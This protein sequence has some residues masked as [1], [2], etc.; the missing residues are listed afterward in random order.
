MRT[1]V[2]SLDVLPMTQRPEPSG[3]RVSDRSGNAGELDPGALTNAELVSLAQRE[4]IRGVA[5]MHQRFSSEVNRL[6]WRLLGADP[7]HNDL[8]QQVFVK[9]LTNSHRLREP[10]RLGAWVQSI[11]VNT[12]YEELR[13]REVR[14]IFLR[15][16]R[17]PAIYPN[18]VHDV[19][20]RDF[21]V[22]SKTI[23]EKL[24]AKER[25]V[26]MLHFVEGRTL[27]EVA[28]LMDY[29]LATAKRRL[30]AANRRFESLL[31]KNPDLRRLLLERTQ[32]I[33]QLGPDAAASSEEGA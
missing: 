26:F 18:L 24:P 32:R 14:R 8:V 27:A 15:E 3:P 10:D 2:L 1:T 9:V 16:W 6:V 29:S 31:G 4:P 21:L 13:R 19:E 25:V 23:I 17:E 30:S 11:T 28:E 12:V 33:E 22:Q 5:L 7:D 20:V